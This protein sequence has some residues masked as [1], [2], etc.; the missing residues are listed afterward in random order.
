LLI[1]PQAVVLDPIQLN[2]ELVA[3]GATALWLTA[4]L[5]HAYHTALAEAFGGLRYL[6]TGGDIVDPRHAAQVLALPKPPRHLINGYGPTETTTFA[7]THII[8]EANGLPLPIGRPIANTQIYI[9]DAEMQPVP[10]GV[11]GEIYIGGIGVSR[12]YLNRPELTVERFIANPFSVGKIYKTGDLGRWRT[13]GVI[14]YLGRNDFQIKLR[15]FRIELGEIE[16]ALLACPNV[17]EAVVL[18]REDH[19]GDKKLVAY[20]VSKIGATLEA[21]VLRS[22]LARVLPDYMLPAAYVVLEALP[23]THNGKLDRQALPVPDGAATASRQYEPAQNPT[24][25]AIIELWQTLLNVERVGRNDHFFELGGH[26]LLAVQL[27][28]RLKDL[29]GVDIP[30]RAFFENP[31]LADFV[32]YVTV[33]QLAA[34]DGS[35]YDALASELAGLSEEELRALL[36]ENT[37]E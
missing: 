7:T 14:E 33:L 32:D 5:F 27:A 31:I 6:L 36:A 30:L 8:T 29:L 22:E 15:G 20:L 28:V 21:A 12:G 25:T 3:G 13:D 23:L 34:Y 9:L 17:R 26:S 24:E 10:I 2:R 4:G 35:E 19:V 16:A 37:D 18:A 11:I 1:V